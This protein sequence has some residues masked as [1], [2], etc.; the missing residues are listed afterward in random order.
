MRGWVVVC[1]LHCVV[2]LSSLSFTVCCGLCALHCTAHSTVF[3]SSDQCY[4]I[5]VVV[6][7]N[8]SSNFFP[9]PF[10]SSLNMRPLLNK[11]PA[12]PVVWSNFNDKE[13]AAKF[14]TKCPLNRTMYSRTNTS[15]VVWKSHSLPGHERVHASRELAAYNCA[16]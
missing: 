7:Q 4:G 10:M 3:M 9:V 5:V 6:I 12:V 11:F 16:N 2:G 14:E 1:T 15:V 8:N 13:C